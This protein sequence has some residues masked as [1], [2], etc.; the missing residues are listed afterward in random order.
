MI[1]YYMKFDFSLT[2]LINSHNEKNKNLV[3]LQ[4]EL[5]IIQP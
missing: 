4:L 2:F 1:G 3:C 5:E